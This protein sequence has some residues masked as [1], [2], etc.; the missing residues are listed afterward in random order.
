MGVER[1]P[2]GVLRTADET[3][4]EAYKLLDSGRPFHA[5]EVFEDAWKASPAGDRREFWRGMA[6]LAVGVTHAAR[7]N[8]AGAVSLLRR[9][10]STVRA[11]ADGAPDGLDVDAITGWASESIVRVEAGVPVTLSAPPLGVI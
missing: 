7:G 5:H 2:E 9:G 8:G 6:Q 11:H 3:L 10:A 4:T 1:A